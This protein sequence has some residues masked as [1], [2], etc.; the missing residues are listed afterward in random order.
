MK[1]LLA[2]FTILLAVFSTTSSSPVHAEPPEERLLVFAGI[3]PVAGI[4][5]RVGGRHVDV[6]VLV[7]P[8]RDPH[9]YEPT[10]K[11]LATLAKAR[12]F[13]TIG[14]PFENTLLKKIR[15]TFKNLKVID[16]SKG[17]R[18]RHFDVHETK[19]THADHHKDGHS[20]HGHAREAESSDMH[21]WLDPIRVKTIAANIGQ[22]LSK[23]DPDRASEY[24]KNLERFQADVDA[25][26]E[27]IA[28]R[29]HSLRG[30]EFFVFHPAFGYFADRYGLKQ[31]AVEAEGKEPSARQLAKLI[32]LAK[33]KRVKVIFVQPQFS[34]NSADAIADAIEGV[35]VPMDPLAK[36]YLKN[37]EDMADKVEK[38]L[39][40]RKKK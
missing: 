29:L 15:P 12:A 16:A 37:L 8:G 4:V 27:K 13:F 31:V 5:E 6:R 30:R 7:G 28:R 18:V 33:A 25:T 17:I 1:Q 23:M 19:G 14:L 24:K 2:G 26:H 20:H 10:P 11:Q 22:G 34:K 32:S 3:S 39:S 38:A 21:I 36:D 9:S 35:V 40:E